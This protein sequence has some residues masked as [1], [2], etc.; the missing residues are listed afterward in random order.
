MK[1]KLECPENKDIIHDYHYYEN[2]HILQK[3]KISC[4][5]ENISVDD[6]ADLFMQRAKNICCSI[7]DRVKDKAVE[8][9]TENV[10]KRKNKYAKH[11]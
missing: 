11:Q 2:E 3:N 4:E 10:K 1:E 5:Y 9:S 6:I 8:K 7:F